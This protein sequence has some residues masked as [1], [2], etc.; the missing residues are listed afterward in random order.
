[1]GRLGAIFGFGAGVLLAG[2]AFAQMAGPAFG[3]MG[4]PLSRAMAAQHASTLGITDVDRRRLASAADRLAPQRPGVVDAYVV[5]AALD[6]DP[7]FARE[8]REAGKVLS[9]RYDAGGR[10]L[11]L[12]GGDGR[13]IEALPRGSLETL[14]TALK[15][16]A[17]VMDPE[18]DALILYITAHGTPQGIAYRDQGEFL[19]TLPPSWLDYVLRHE[20]LRNRVL[21]ISACY[22]GLFVPKL[23]TPEGA[24]ITAA[25]ADRTSFG[26][27]SDNDWTF[28]GDALINHA[29]R[30]N[31]P[32]AAAFGEA[33]KMV[34]AWEAQGKLIP[35]QP[36]IA[37]G[38]EAAKWLGPAEAKMPKVASAPVGRPAVDAMEL[39]V[40]ANH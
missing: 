40:R 30:K 1:M 12:A 13:S 5:V 23:A 35:S 22:S 10:T 34:G 36:Q 24:V 16:V 17:A 33:S 7:V 14:E 18:E 15:R 4:D 26:C 11:V 19:A 39:A 27:A 3:P 8:A 29:L 21:I 37:V 25:A 9:A 32:L 38:A 2:G 6:S 28:F 31:Q 20:H